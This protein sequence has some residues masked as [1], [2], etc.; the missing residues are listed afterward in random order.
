ML[1]ELLL[2]YEMARGSAAL[3]DV[4]GRGKIEAEGNDA[5]VFLHNLSTNDVKDL[6]P[7][8]GRELFFCTAT[9]KVVAYGRVYREAPQGKRERLWVDVG[10]TQ[11]EKLFRH[12]D[13]Y[14]ISEDVTLTD[15]TAELAQLHLAGPDAA[16]VLKT[17]IGE[18]PADWGPGRFATLTLPD[19][20]PL[21]VRDS[22]L[23]GLEGF[24]LLCAAARAEKLKGRL[25]EAGAKP[26]GRE[27]YQVLRV[28][29]GM[30]EY[31]VDMDEN[32]FAPEVGRMEAI[33]FQKGCYLGQE[34]IVM[35][36][37]R[38]VVQRSLVGLLLGDEP[39]TGVLY[40]DGKEVGRVTSS[41]LSPRLGCA[42]GLG[43]VKRGSQ[44]PGT[45][46]E[47]ESTAG[48]RVVKVARLPLGVPGQ[49]A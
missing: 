39:A 37:D 4:S 28:E 40:R 47:L 36:R 30:P 18:L 33:S 46:L 20:A 13:R 49:I 43:Y 19:G 3:F 38:G 22:R 17:V 6:P 41:V 29:A 27:T 16:R 15:R 25:V 24:D 9:A 21:T 2:E 11:G 42:V 1:G 14:L 23:L 35:A 32:T 5:A 48:K 31:G 10:E 7:G 26:A 44:T 34:P 45:E 12:L 8:S